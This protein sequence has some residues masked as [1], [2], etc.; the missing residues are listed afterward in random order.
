M[1][2]YF[3]YVIVWLIF[4]ICAYVYAQK[5]GANPYLYT[6]LVFIFPFM[7]I[8]LPFIKKSEYKILEEN[9]A[10]RVQQI[11]PRRTVNMYGHQTEPKNNLSNSSNEQKNLKKDVNVSVKFN[12]Q[13][14]IFYRHGEKFL[15]YLRNELGEVTD[16]IF[17]EINE[18]VQTSDKKE[19]PLL[20]SH[21]LG[22][23]RADKQLRGRTYF[24]IFEQIE[25]GEKFLELQHS[26]KLKKGKVSINFEI[27]SAH[28]SDAYHVYETISKEGPAQELQDHIEC[29]TAAK[30]YI[31][32]RPSDSPW[33]EFASALTLAS[34]FSKCESSEPNELDNSLALV[35]IENKK[36]KV[37]EILDILPKDKNIPIYH[38]NSHKPR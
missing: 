31:E 25:E 15:S 32:Q 5:K 9:N 1:S 22:Y 12:V 8:F 37:F 11:S 10:K 7:I 29:L 3:G 17:S 27:Q 28:L 18:L 23:K 14:A 21:V 30:I 38:S 34:R 24:F 19:G 33:V 36:V 4:I 16:R 6:G 26:I 20:P 13:D 2:D 35:Y